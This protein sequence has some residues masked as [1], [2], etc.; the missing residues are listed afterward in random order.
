MKRI[1]FNIF[2]CLLLSC[3]D[4]SD[5]NL[6]PSRLKN[7]PQTA[8]W[9]DGTDGGSWFVI[10]EIH[11]HKNAATIEIYNDQDGSLIVSKQFVLICNL[12]NSGFVESQYFSILDSLPKQILGFDGEKIILKTVFNNKNCVLQ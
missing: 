3:T 11:S 8:F 4:T 9:L 7:I 5:N 1:F 6:A 2:F 12:D 10:K